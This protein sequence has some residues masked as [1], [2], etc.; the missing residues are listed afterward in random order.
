M[1][2]MQF[3]QIFRGNSTRKN[4]GNPMNRDELP[5]DILQVVRDCAVGL[6]EIND[7]HVNCYQLKRNVMSAL[8]KDGRRIEKRMMPALEDEMQYAAARAM[9]MHLFSGF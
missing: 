6:A 2:I 4:R 7:G 9:S 5:Q 1:R 8:R 3:R